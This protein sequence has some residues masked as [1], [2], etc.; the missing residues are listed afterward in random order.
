[1]CGFGLAGPS[2]ES[3]QLKG[4]CLDL[5]CSSAA[6]TLSPTWQSLASLLVQLHLLSPS[7]QQRQISLARPL[8]VCTWSQLL[9]LSTTR[10]KL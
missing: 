10:Q 1:M 3:V 5:A 9:N 7:W 2:V 6:S 4:L 8:P